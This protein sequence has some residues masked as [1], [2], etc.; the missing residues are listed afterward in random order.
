MSRSHDAYLLATAAVRRQRD[1][2]T[3]T[4]LAVRLTGGSVDRRE[5]RRALALMGQAF[6]LAGWKP[7]VRVH[8]GRRVWS[9]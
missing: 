3:S 1:D 2:V 5:L 6:I 9:L 8:A 4:L 7:R